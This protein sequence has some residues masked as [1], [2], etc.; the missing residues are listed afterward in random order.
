MNKYIESDRL[1]ENRI[2]IAR[3]RSQMFNLSELEQEKAGQEIKNILESCREELDSLAI[4][5]QADRL[6]NMGY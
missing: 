5:K 1:K 4:Q 6:T 3:L 2:K